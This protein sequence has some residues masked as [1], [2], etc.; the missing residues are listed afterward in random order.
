ML[1]LLLVTS[2]ENDWKWNVNG[3]FSAVREMLNSTLK[4]TRSLM[5]KEVFG[6]TKKEIYSF[7]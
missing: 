5:E 7:C 3:W 1:I 4:E 2:C 6:L